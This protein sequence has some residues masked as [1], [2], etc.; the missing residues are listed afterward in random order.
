MVSLHPAGIL[1]SMKPFNLSR[2]LSEQGL[3]PTVLARHLRVSEAYLGTVLA[4]EEA[5]GERDQVA[6][7]ALAARLA[8][9]RQALRAVQIELP[10]GDPAVTFTRDYARQR[11]RERVETHAGPTPRAKKSGRPVRSS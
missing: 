2:F 5:L 6:C 10:F 8:R 7:L 11:A 1:A 9:E 3:S 4:G